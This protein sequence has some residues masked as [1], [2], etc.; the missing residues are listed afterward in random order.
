[1]FSLAAI[2]STLADS[3][4]RFGYGAVPGIPDIHVDLTGFWAA[5]PGASHLDFASAVT[6]FVPVRTDSTTQVCGVE[7]GPNAP[8]TIRTSL[9]GDSLDLFFPNGATLIS[10]SVQ[11]PFLSWPQRSVG[12]NV[13]T[14][15]VKWILVS[16]STA[17]PPLL[18]GLSGESNGFKVTGN[19]G[20]WTI[21]SP[22]FS[23]WLRVWLPFGLDPKFATDAAGLGAI[24]QSVE[25]F[26]NV[27][28]S[29]TPI[30]KSSA[31][32]ATDSAID[33]TWT[34]SGPGAF[35]PQAPL[36]A[37]LGGASLAIESKYRTLPGA[38]MDG[39]RA[40]VEGTTLVVHFPCLKM[41]F[42]RALGLGTLSAEPLAT[43][44]ATDPPSIVELANELLLAWG[45]DA[46]LKLADDTVTRFLT[47]SPYVVEPA[48]GQQLPYGPDSAGIV[49]ASAQS[50]LD[51]CAMVAL[52]SSQPNALFDSILWRRDWWT[53]TIWT[54]EQENSRRATC[55]AALAGAFSSDPNARF[56][57]ATLEAG[58]DAQR[59]LEV[60]RTRRKLPNKVA[61]LEEPLLGMRTGF[62]GLTRIR[63]T[64][65]DFFHLLQSPVKLG[66]GP[67]VALLPANPQFFL[68][69]RSDS[70]KPASLNLFGQSW[71]LA[72]D[73]LEN[74]D[75][76]VLHKEKDGFKLDYQPV[77]L[78][79]CRVA[80]VFTPALDMI[81]KEVVPPQ[82]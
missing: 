30:V 10:R 11:A 36:M 3:F 9:V 80:V 67:A 72:A 33:S 40:V 51:Q 43:V 79:T 38:G 58:L 49:M 69:W 12:P 65:M 47:D 18:L 2:A 4:G 35:V 75:K 73:K 76:L 78:G 19:T 31:I 20:A 7:G 42:G 60:W 21:G 54:G 70:G 62:F 23:G 28:A 46:L 5:Y 68:E 61:T 17:E 52:S 25:P 39:P 37:P 63:E 29:V 44:A 27:W 55:L 45:D 32:K 16:F 77:T 1:L 66:P 24:T 74:I 50:Y 48:T 26:A 64:N 8:R 56:Y 15:D 81:P 13:P 53:W 71:Q 22:D 6:R 82:F 34:F 57:G 41:K 59:G 14:Q